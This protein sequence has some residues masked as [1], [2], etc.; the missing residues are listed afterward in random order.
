[1]MQSSSFKNEKSS[2]YK[3]RFIK[4]SIRIRFVVYPIVALLVLFF[5]RTRYTVYAY[6]FV[7]AI[8][9]ILL[10]NSSLRYLFKFR[11]SRYTMGIFMFGLDAV[12]IG[13]TI[14]LTGGIQSPFF[15]L[16]LLHFLALAF[17]SSSILNIFFFLFDSSLYLI[18]SYFYKVIFENHS[19]WEKAIIKFG[20]GP[21]E[22][23]LINLSV[24]ILIAGIVTYITHRLN[25]VSSKLSDNRKKM[26]FLLT[27]EDE[28][29]KLK[30]VDVFLRETTNMI[31]HTFGYT[32]SA[33][34][35]LNNE[36]TEINI[37]E[38]SPQISI[39]ELDS[40]FGI[41]IGKIKVPM[42][43]THN[44][45]IKAVKERSTYITHKEWDLLIDAIPSF[46]EK[47]AEQIQEAT[48]NK[49]FI[50]IPIVVFGDIMGV[51]EVESPQEYIN[52][53]DVRLLEKFASSIGMSIINN[54]LYTETLDQKKE[55][56]RHYHEMNAML[57]ELQLSYSKLE[58]F[59]TELEI[60][61]NKLE[62]MK[63]ILY[64]TDK[65]ASIGQVIASITHQF[66]SPITAISGQ[67]EMLVKELNDK[68]IDTGKDRL[69][70]IKLSVNKLSNSVRKL[71]LSVRQTKPEFKDVNINDTIKSV[72]GLWEYELEKTN[73]DVSIKLTDTLPVI[74]AIPDAIEQ[75]LVN[76]ISNARDAMQNKKGRLTISTRL[77]DKENVE[78]EVS[79]EGIGISNE[80]LARIFTPFFST[81]P[82]GKGTG[83][84]M[85]IAM[86]VVEGHNG[87][88][89]VK[90]EL[91]KGT[92]FTI[93][94]PIKHK[95]NNEHAK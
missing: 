15:S 22:L 20:P 50:V 65:L 36:K 86:K 31:R 3:E 21:G 81:K 45:A 39:E 82:A 53:D 30:P 54:R 28:S 92:I 79:D 44:V 49:T 58:N 23:I 25:V 88:I 40:R 56:E 62:E 75:L 77:F 38:H 68:G 78:L 94:L 60:S 64:H 76:L 10:L 48:N 43:S 13:F 61:K 74:E 19:I 17:F 91:N 24:F 27:M 1:M 69:K 29:K 47:M 33:I 37:N 41:G 9:F 32:Y 26:N 95:I 70:M 83:L 35:L 16:F 66:S 14:F 89:M 12:I 55:I 80:N 90:S 6:F 93:I 84:G 73:V 59:T 5:I 67:V 51:L 2:P 71:M 34:A 63:G 11:K 57:N 72:I 87:R 46:T 7:A 8:V 52:K 42:T 4:W 18:A 85:V